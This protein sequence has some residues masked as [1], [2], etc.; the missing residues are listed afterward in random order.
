MN[1]YDDIK[2]FLE[3]SKT[4]DIDYK[5]IN[6][7]STGNGMTGSMNQWALIKQVSASEE[8]QSTLDNGRTTQPTPQA[9][10]AE[11][12]QRSA[13]LTHERSSTPVAAAPSAAPFVA[14]PTTV[15][16]L[17]SAIAP[18]P[19]GLMDALRESLPLAPQ[20]SVSSQAPTAQA[21]APHSAAILHAQSV[22][23]DSTGS[24]LDSVKHALPD[25]PVA[26]APAYTAPVAAPVRPAPVPTWT[27]AAAAAVP[28]HA[29]SAPNGQFRQMF[30]QKAPP[31]A[32]A[33][34][35]RDTPLQP[36]L[37]MIAS[38]R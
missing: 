34:L 33:F 31:S 27:Q 13:P 14:I 12:F 11:E 18:A 30:K 4:E 26:P 28:A 21:S 29:A 32:G 25:Q 9:I 5:E 8:A 16:T 2:R 1:K 23:P 22:T 36:L 38:C 3:K 10:S 17:S 6:E 15:N 35:H 7:K 20:P 37:E 24:L 19:G